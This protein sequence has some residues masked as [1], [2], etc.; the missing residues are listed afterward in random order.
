MDLLDIFM[1]PTVIN[2]QLLSQNAGL[3]LLLSLQLQ[4]FK[5]WNISD[6]G[7]HTQISMIPALTINK[8]MKPS[9]KT[10]GH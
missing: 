3:L 2:T 9:L 10:E 5:G 1:S 7:S 6:L 4:Q 8:Q